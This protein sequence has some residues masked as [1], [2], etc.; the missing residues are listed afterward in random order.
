[1]EHAI[2]GKQCQARTVRIVLLRTLSTPHATGWHPVAATNEPHLCALSASRRPVA[3]GKM[4]T[5]IDVAQDVKLQDTANL[6]PQVD[7]S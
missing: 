2:T 7:N 4:G 5:Q 6:V 3:A 1:M